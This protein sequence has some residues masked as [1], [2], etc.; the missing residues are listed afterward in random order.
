MI[1]WK[2]GTGNMELTQYSIV[3]VDLGEHQGAGIKKVRPCVV[4]SPDEM[5]RYLRTVVVAPMT[6]RARTYPTRVRVRH[7]KQTAWI[8]VDQLTTLDRA[9]VKRSLGK[10]THPE[11]RK[12]KMVIRETYVD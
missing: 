4:V 1:S 9:R 7:N 2:S 12:L 8:V 11:I 3:L 10:L 6:T 5:N